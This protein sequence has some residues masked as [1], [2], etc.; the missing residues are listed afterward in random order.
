MSR[1]KS[2]S[3]EQP[4]AESESVESAGGEMTED[5]LEEAVGGVSSGEE[6][7][8]ESAEE[9]SGSRWWTDPDR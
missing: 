7:S 2:V 6:Q 5:E 9:S 3:K 1:Q 8:P 4:A